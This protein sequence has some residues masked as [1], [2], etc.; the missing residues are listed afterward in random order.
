MPRI[1]I[2]KNL[3]ASLLTHCVTTILFKWLVFLP[4]MSDAD[5]DSTLHEVRNSCE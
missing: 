1:A 2:H 4:Y 5:K 3:F